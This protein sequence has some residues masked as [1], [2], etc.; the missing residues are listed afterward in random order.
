MLEV[1]K[2]ID[3]I[4]SAMSLEQ[5]IGGVLVV[6]FLGTA[7]HR[8]A[9]EMIEQLH[10][11]GLRI[12]TTIR[13]KQ[14]YASEHGDAAAHLMADGRPTGP[15]RDLEANYHP[16]F[17]TPGEY[18][19]TLNRLREAALSRPLGLPLHITLDQEGNGNEN[20][21]LGRPRL[22]PAQM[23]L[24]AAKDPRLVYQASRVIATQLKVAGMD[25][26]HSPVLD[27]NTDP[28]NYEIATRAFSDDT[29]VVAR[30][31]LQMFEALRASGMIATGKHF[32]GR[33]HS[34]VDSH[35][36]LPTIDLSKEELEAVHMM[37]FAELIKAG[38]PSIMSAH[39]SYPALDNSGDP[40]S[41]SKTIFTD[42]LKGELGFEGVVTTDNM[43][44]GGVVKKYGVP[45]ACVRALAA[46][47]DLLLLR[48]QSD[49]CHVV[50]D[51]IRTAVEDGTLPI[52]R[53]DDA[54]RRVLSVKMEYGL[55]DAHVAPDQ[56]AIERVQTSP[57]AR[58]I[59]RK[60]ASGALE[61]RDTLGLLPFAPTQR[62]LLIEGVHTTHRVVNNCE[63]HPSIFTEIMQEYVAKLAAVEVARFDEC[64]FERVRR[65]LPEAAVIVVTNWVERRGATD[66][67]SFVRQLQTFGLPVAVVT[68]SPF[69]VG[70]PPDLPTVL[71]TYSTNPESMRAVCESLFATGA[72]P[73]H[74]ESL[75]HVPGHPA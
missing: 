3:D 32:P 68:N 5:K 44:M 48:S 14:T 40:A 39:T 6:D 1:K 25:W 62:I 28:E 66:N 74:R 41:L 70:A 4:V 63:C 75:Q 12:D 37:P 50:F 29:E 7:P 47:N 9:F 67:A 21:C 18:L 34:R 8:Q 11:A 60:A 42:I 31:G 33:G 20:Y 27:G 73:E 30:Y 59:E 71:V 53:L 46:G 72:L 10:V 38:I 45:D 17:C 43:L 54:N 57:Q 19:Q 35:Y 49:L 23:G 52:E 15:A 56:A 2:M 69:G 55:L 58:I 26:M 22:F 61:V 64:A 65:R 16:P 36:E 51:R 24:A 13:T